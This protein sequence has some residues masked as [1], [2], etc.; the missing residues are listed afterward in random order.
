MGDDFLA[1]LTGE[2]IAKV[3]RVTIA[4]A[5]TIFTLFI[6]GVFSASFMTL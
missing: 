5:H 4:I 2:A 3:A 6:L 1:A